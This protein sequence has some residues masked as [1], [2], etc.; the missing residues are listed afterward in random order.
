MVLFVKGILDGSIT[1]E[2][3]DNA[4]KLL[5]PILEKIEEGESV[6]NIANELSQKQ[7]YFENECGGKWQGQTVMA[8]VCIFDYYDQYSGKLNDTGKFLGRAL[9]KSTCSLEVKEAAKE[10]LEMIHY[11]NEL[12]A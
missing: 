11:L 10:M 6:E 7:Q 5:K 9:L 4:R 12:Q 3:I 8:A 2:H 1:L